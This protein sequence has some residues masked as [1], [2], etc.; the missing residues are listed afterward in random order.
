MGDA[1]NLPTSKTAAA[2]F[3][4]APVVVHNV[5]RMLG[6]EGRTAKSDGYACCPVFT[7]GKKIML[8]EF[9]YGDPNNP[10]FYPD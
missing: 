3:G 7:G 4:Q 10:T 5:L 8:C 2:T 9:K 6:M 1:A